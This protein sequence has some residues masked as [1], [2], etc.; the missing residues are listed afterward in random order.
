MNTIE[1]AYR[2][3]SRKRFPLP[4]EKQVESLERRMNLTLPDD[5]RRFILEF[6]GGVF[7]EPVF[8][9]EGGFRDRLTAM[10]G[11]GASYEAGELENLSNLS[12]F[13]DNDP[14][15]I[16]PIGDT[17][18][19]GLIILHVHP[20]VSGAIFYKQAYGDFYYQADDIE[21]FFAMLREPEEE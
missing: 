1:F 19:G 9:F 7:T 5:Y 12:L 13:D 18:M 2:Q 6:N 10:Y 11:I 20:E 8:E 14:P 4:S 15:E 21:E 16:L 17:M 3:F